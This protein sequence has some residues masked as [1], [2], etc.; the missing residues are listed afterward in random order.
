MQKTRI[1][2]YVTDVAVVV[3]FWQ[4]HFDLPV[5]ATS[6]L[7]DG[8]ENVVLAMNPGTEL[9]FFSRAFIQKYSP[10]VLDNVPSLM[11]FSE[12]FA[13]LHAELPGATPIV[14][15]NGQPAF[16][17]PDPEGHYYAVGKA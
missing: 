17:F 10:E 8:S 11:F 5:V 9:S 13:A 7:P 15:D 6:P 16:G 14:D 4:D 3:K 2:L 1:M 12:R